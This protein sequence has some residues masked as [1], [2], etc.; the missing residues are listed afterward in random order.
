MLWIMV[1]QKN[2]NFKEEKMINRIT[3]WTI[4]II[5]CQ[6]KNIPTIILLQIMEK[7][8]KNLNQQTLIKSQQIKMTEQM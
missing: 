3:S 5:Q 7:E 1:R 8:L 4:K 6:T 2:K